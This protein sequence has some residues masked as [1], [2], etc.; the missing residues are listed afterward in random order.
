MYNFIYK[1]KDINI[2][3]LYSY[4]CLNRAI[5]KAGILCIPNIYFQYLQKQKLKNYPV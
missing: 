2:V 1:G 5:N 4:T 3:L